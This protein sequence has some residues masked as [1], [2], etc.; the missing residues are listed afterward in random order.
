MKTMYFKTNYNQKL[1]CAGFVHIDRAPKDPVPSSALNQPLEIRTL[2]NTHPPVHKRLTSLTRFRLGEAVDCFTI[3]SHG[4]DACD[5]INWWKKEN[6]EEEGAN[7][8]I[9][10]YQDVQEN[11]V[12]S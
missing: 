11:S 8:A 3:P 4:M 2:D 5:F 7:L 6:K 9:Y 10:F 12:S 1:G